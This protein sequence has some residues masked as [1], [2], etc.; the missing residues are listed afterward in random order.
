MALSPPTN[1]AAFFIEKRAPLVVKPSTYTPPGENEIVIENAAVAIN[2]YDWVL[3]EAYN[4]IIPNMKL[5]FILGTDVAGQVFEVGKGVTRFQKGDRVVAHAMGLGKTIVKASEGG[6]QQ[7]TVIREHMASTIPQDMAFETAAVM[8]LG[9]S[10]AACALYMN[11][12]LALPL[13]TH[14]TPKSTGTTVLIWG[15]STSVG[16]NA[17]Q[18]A[19]ASGI[20][21]IS[22]SSPKN[23]E[24]L[25]QLGASEV[26]DYNS[27]TCVADIVKAFN[28]TT[29]AGAI[30][31]GPGSVSKC[32]EVL[33][34]VKGKRFVAQA[35]LD[36]PPFPKGG[37]DMVP[38][39][40]SFMKGTIGIKLQQRVKGV[41]VKFLNGDDLES[42]EVGPAIYRE[43]LPK[44]LQDKTIVP[45]PK[46]RVIGKGLDCVQ[47][48]M[49]LN[50]KG[51]SAEKIV[52]TL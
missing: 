42:N 25:K 29:S 33:S 17:I 35:T 7:Y 12:Y 22:T 13:P 48:G 11:D 30:S 18:L 3:Q 38:F 24:Y 20:K 52:V 26:F 51:V 21:V 9:L 1:N 6:F 40:F 49:D 5:P 36:L 4:F 34:Q 45:A 37:L 27:K 28:G 32:M 43:F 47:Q 44:A 14:A 41:Q 8:P 50:K 10:T 19:V 39:L 23:F 16:C 31:I 46:A 2:P 15:G